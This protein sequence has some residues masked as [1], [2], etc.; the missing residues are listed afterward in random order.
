ME[1]KLN[2]FTVRPGTLS[3]LP[4]LARPTHWKFSKSGLKVNLWVPLKGVTLKEPQALYSRR[5]SFIQSWVSPV[6]RFLHGT[7]CLWPKLMQLSEAKSNI[8]DLAYDNN[9]DALPAS[10]VCFI[11]GRFLSTPYWAISE[12]NYDHQIIS[13]HLICLQQ[14]QIR[15]SN[16]MNGEISTIRPQWILW[17]TNNFKMVGHSLGTKFNGPRDSISFWLVFL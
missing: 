10:R 15:N 3:M 5:G 7:G 6:N 4:A 14:N 12:P 11:L 16:A 9:Y 13:R 17:C 1:P 2:C 8:W